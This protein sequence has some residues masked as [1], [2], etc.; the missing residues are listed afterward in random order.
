MGSNLSTFFSS[1]TVSIETKCWMVGFNE[2]AVTGAMRI[3][4]G[5]PY[6]LSLSL[7]LSL[8]GSIAIW[9]LATFSVS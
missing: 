2:S 6:S 3:G 4:R 5:N 8:Y 7:S 1:I 9:T